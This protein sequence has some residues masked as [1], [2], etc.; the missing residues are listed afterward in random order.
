[1]Q[2]NF[3]EKE[4][5][6]CLNH[7]SVLQK[8][9]Y[10]LY[11]MQA[12]QRAEWNHA[13]EYAVFQANKFRK[14]LFVFFGLTTDFPEANQRHYKFMLEGL[15]ETKEKLLKRRIKMIIKI[16]SPDV[17]VI[18]IAKKAIL[19][20]VDRGYLRIQ[21][22][23]REQVAKN[24]TCPLWQVES[25]TVV[26]VETASDHEEY[27]AYTLRPKIHKMLRYFMKPVEEIEPEF[28]SLNLEQTRQEA[29]LSNIENLIKTLP[30]DKTV[31]TVPL[32]GGTEE[33]KKKLKLFIEQ[34]L[35]YYARWRNNPTK[36]VLSEIS[37]YLHFGQISPLFIAQQVTNADCSEHAAQEAYLE[38]LIVRR[39]LAL[40]F[41][42][43]NSNYDSPNS[44]PGW[45]Q[46]TLK[47]HSK[48]LRKYTYTMEEFEQAKTHDPL[49]NAAQKE[50]LLTGK[51]HGYLRMY[52]GKKILEWS[53]KPEEAFLIALHLNNKY[54]L[55]GRDANSFA[56]VA[57]C[58]GKHDRA[59]PERPIFGK[60][61]YMS[62][63]GMQ[64]KFPVQKYIQKIEKLANQLRK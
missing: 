47:K 56:G 19:A 36:N 23:W 39:E 58:F 45:A 3:V 60:V 26:P 32:K 24:I 38:E 59:F 18:E 5:I 13:L 55:D 9:D 15:K 22:K 31:M 35:P 1:M 49:W 57:W 42:F 46:E 50:L 41:V 37:P 14:P 29:D 33:A 10:L 25:E 43:Y 63:K 52:W 8:G 44:L 53:E 61:R 64:S 20:I 28:S 16:G 21:R 12:S 27:G 48:D 17:D 2:Q 54:A 6:K 51:I 62:L 11:W 34:K 4:R 40:N 30:I 7:L